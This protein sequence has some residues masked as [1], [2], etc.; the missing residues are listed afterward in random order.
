M[1]IIGTVLNVNGTVYVRS[2]D[3]SIRTLKPGDK[4]YEGEVL[5][6]AEGGSVELQM[7]DGSSV[8]VDENR[9]IG[10]T[11]DFV[12]QSKE[13][14][15]DGQQED[16][17]YRYDPLLIQDAKDVEDDGSTYSYVQ[18]GYLRVEK[19]EAP[20]DSPDYRFVSIVGSY[21]SSLGGR[22]GSGDPMSDG[23]AT[24]DPRIEL[25]L[26]PPDREA[27]EEVIRVFQEFEDGDR[28]ILDTQPEIGTPEDAIVDEDDLVPD[29]TDQ[30]DDPVDGGSLDVIPGREALDTFFDGNTPPVGLTSGGESVNYYVSSDGHTLIGYTGELPASGIPDADQQVFEVVINNPDSQTGEQSYTYTQID[31]LDHP[32]GEGEN[33][34]VLTFNFT[35]EDTDGDSAA[36]S[37]N[38]TVIDDIPIAAVSYT[39][40]RAHET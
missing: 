4:I 27:Q 40:L 33:D 38:V 24:H 31:Q 35:A 37:F 34:L 9:E 36:S 23:R 11:S 18:H 26:A 19:S 10:M 7:P 25:S 28:R 32:D 3:G 30:S 12:E 20:P 39:H 5:I 8:F 29:G 17:G 15:P 16:D 22:T 21:N 13:I 2:E 1:D 14:G 6:T